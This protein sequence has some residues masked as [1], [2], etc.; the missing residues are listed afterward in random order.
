M[1]ITAP[2]ATLADGTSASVAHIPA[3]WDWIDAITTEVNALNVGGGEGEA[4]IINVAKSGG[5]YDT[6][7]DKLADAD[8]GDVVVVF[9]GDYAENVT[10]AVAGLWCL[11]TKLGTSGVVTISEADGP[12]HTI[13]EIAQTTR[14]LV[15][16]S[17]AT[18]TWAGGSSDGMTV[19]LSSSGEM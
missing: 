19:W 18:G 7:A 14:V 4:G 2:E 1:T 8:P 10:D 13:V 3:L 11:D 17:N 12:Y 9:P 16:L 6:I 5:D 15:R